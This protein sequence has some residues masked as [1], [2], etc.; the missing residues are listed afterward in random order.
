[1]S[2]FFCHLYASYE[3]NTHTTW[4]CVPGTE[5]SYNC[6]LFL[7]VLSSIFISRASLFPSADI[8]NRHWVRDCARGRTNKP[9]I[10]QPLKQNKNVS[11]GTPKKLTW[12]SACL[13]SQNS[14]DRR[15]SLELCDPLCGW[16]T[17]HCFVPVYYYHCIIYNQT[18]RTYNH[19]WICAVYSMI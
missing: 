1:M 9:A 8:V 17:L 15:I 7:G 3:Q 13:L 19:C 18:R 5:Y 12:I 16:N 6:Y 4:M 2:S 10:V 11:Y 14:L